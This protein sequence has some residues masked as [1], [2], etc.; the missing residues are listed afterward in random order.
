MDDYEE[1]LWP[2]PVALLRTLVANSPE[3]NVKVALINVIDYLSEESEEA[4]EAGEFRTL[5]A[6]DLME[7]ISQCLAYLHHHVGEEEDEDGFHVEFTEP[8][9]KKPA[10]PSPTAEELL[11]MFREQLGETDGKE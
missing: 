3:M 5:S 10:T 11:S 2:D 9:P 4:R 6:N 1:H 7:V 8:V